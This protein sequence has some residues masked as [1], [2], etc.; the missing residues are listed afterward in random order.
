[1]N[2]DCIDE[3]CQICDENNRCTRCKDGYGLFYDDTCAKCPDSCETCGYYSGFS[4][5][6]CK[7]CKISYYP[8]Q[9][10]DP[11]FSLC[12]SCNEQQSGCLRCTTYD[13]CEACFSNY[14]LNTQTSQCSP[15]TEPCET[16][17]DEATKC[18]SC[19]DGY[20]LDNSTNK[21]FTCPANCRHC[22][23]NQCTECNDKFY[24]SGSSCLPCEKS[25]CLKCS[26]AETCTDCEI[27]FY[28][29]NENSCSSCGENCVECTSE[30]CTICKHEFYPAEGTSCKPC[31]EVCS[32]CSGPT[33]QDCISCDPGYFFSGPNRNCFK[34]H[35]SCANCT[36]PNND[37]CEGCSVGYFLTNGI[38][39][40]CEAGCLECES[41]IMCNKCKDGFYLSGNNKDKDCIP[42][43]AGCMTC[44]E[45]GEHQ[46]T[47]CFPGYHQTTISGT[48][49]V[50]CSP[51]PEN[52]DTCQNQNGQLECTDCRD[53]YYKEGDK[54]TR[55]DS[56][57]SKC[58]SKE[59]CSECIPGYLHQ[60]NKC[61][62]QCSENCLGCEGTVDKCIS[63]RKGYVLNGNKCESCPEG[64]QFCE[65]NSGSSICLS[66][67][68]GFYKDGY[69]CK[70][71]DPTCETCATS[72][73][74]RCYTCPKGYYKY[75]E[76]NYPYLYAGECK[77]CEEGLTNCAEC[78]SE[79]LDDHINVNGE[80]NFKCTK[81]SPGHF[82]TADS[83]T[84]SSCPLNCFECSDADTCIKCDQG[85][86]L[87][88][89]VC[90]L[91]CKDNIHCDLDNIN[92][93]DYGQ[94]DREEVKYEGT[95][96]P[97]NGG[98]L[99]IINHG[100]SIVN[101]NFTSCKSTEG[102]G[103]AIYIYN[104]IEDET[105]TYSIT[106]INL[107]FAECSAIYGGAVFIYSPSKD[108]PISIKSCNFTENVARGTTNT[109][110]LYGG[111][112]LYLVCVSSEIVDCK[113]NHNKGKG[114]AVKITDDF[115]NVPKGL[116]ILQYE[117][118]ATVG[119]IE[120]K[121][122]TFEIEK[123][124]DCSL[125]YSNNKQISKVNLIDCNFAGDLNKDAHHID[126]QLKEK[127]YS[128]L[129]INSCTFSDEKRAFNKFIK[130]N[131]INDRALANSMFSKQQI[132]SKL[133]LGVATLIFAAIIVFALVIRRQS[134]DDLDNHDSQ[135]ALDDSLKL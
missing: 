41:L 11:Q 18:T 17:K 70:T 65:T 112:A 5:M 90:D 94:Y 52:C 127:D 30:K 95:E 114:G 108:S 100:V 35:E 103:G 64:C 51:C 36:G 86:V 3:N 80:C 49:Y 58:S 134:N 29:D 119:S 98:A 12:Y 63:C 59:V 89:T 67:Q 13:K 24:L 82:L 7:T 106:I 79:C 110:N 125:Y 122:C 121:G 74:H 115:A 93:T 107:S 42:C 10:N 133:W 2:F 97:S 27:G 55:C 57:C 129:F 38:C 120:I 6:T 50:N 96:S 78:E 88:G 28:V 8:T 102:S 116:R 45:N 99:R 34:C 56:S 31:A 23:S 1:M 73:A 26:N 92:G 101:S 118:N 54:C 14:F 66:C 91:S 9:L 53:G 77:K 19:K 104:N 113:F 48:N 130:I 46:C 44:E 33:A 81:C 39:S 128:K 71:C 61:T 21:C 126:G 4:E 87:N 123:N 32:E 20:G 83:L 105:K 37:D 111:S 72:G 15:C 84:C 132:S 124:S 135:N 68:D 109:N 117:S 43:S 25:Q 62:T 76:Y 47:K 40:R 16:C 75:K 22:D 60:N 131:M 69:E 85:Y